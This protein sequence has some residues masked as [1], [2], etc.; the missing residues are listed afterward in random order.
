MEMHLGIILLGCV[1]VAVERD[2]FESRHFREF[3]IVYRTEQ[4]C[5]LYQDISNA[6]IK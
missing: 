1:A 4:R 2:W 6:L 3:E 5:L